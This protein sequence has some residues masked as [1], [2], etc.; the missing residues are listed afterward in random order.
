META[1]PWP[2]SGNGVR[3]ALGAGEGTAG[4]GHRRAQGGRGRAER[5]LAGPGNING[6]RCKF[7]SFIN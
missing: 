1:G 6:L 2:T 4:S 7:R 5:N 3:T